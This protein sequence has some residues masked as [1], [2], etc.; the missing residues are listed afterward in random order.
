MKNE[1]FILV[2][3]ESHQLES[4]GIDLTLEELGPRV[5]LHLLVVPTVESSD[6]HTVLPGTWGSVTL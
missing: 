2:S 6:P 4:L 5:S 3:K 1:P